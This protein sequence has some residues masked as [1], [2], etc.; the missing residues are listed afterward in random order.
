MVIRPV[1][2]G[3]TSAAAEVHRLAFGSDVEADLAF[4]LMRDDAFVPALSFAAEDGGKLL[5]HVLFTRVWLER[6]D[7]KPGFPPPLLAPLAVVPESQR[8]GVGTSLVEA[9]IALARES[10][11]I[12]VFVFGDPAFYGRFG[13]VG[14]AE[15]GVRAPHPVQPEWG[16]QVLELEPGLLGPSGALKVAPPLDSPEM[17]RE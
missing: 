17:W 2:P 6:D 11:E 8:E 14:A 10:G 1:E 4:A 9:A 16:W 7:G 5:G 3:E 12:A 13:F 15:S